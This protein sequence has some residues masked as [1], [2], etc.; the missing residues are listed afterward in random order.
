MEVLKF[1]FFRK[2]KN[3]AFC[4]F[5][6]S[7]QRLPQC[8]HCGKIKC[9]LKTGDCVIRH[10][11]V[12]TTG[13]GMVVRYFYSQIKLYWG[14][15]WF[16]L[17]PSDHKIHHGHIPSIYFEFIIYN[18]FITITCEVEKAP[19]TH[20]H[21]YAY[22]FAFMLQAAVT[23]SLLICKIQTA[24]SGSFCDLWVILCGLVNTV[25]TAGYTCV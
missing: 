21:Q 6:Q 23:A 10:P 13:F 24:W 17:I 14:F 9:M 11:G 25:W 18:P 22:L 8:A 1:W 5:C 2:Q 12:F 4:Y 19:L 7:V 16:I 3:R 15:L 20:L